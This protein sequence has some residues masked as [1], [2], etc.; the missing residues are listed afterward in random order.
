MR[1]LV[2]FLL[3]FQLVAGVLAQELGEGREFQAGQHLMA[4]VAKIEAKHFEKSIRRG[5]KDWQEG[6]LPDVDTEKLNLSTE[7]EKAFRELLKKAHAKIRFEEIGPGAWASRVQGHV[8]SFSLKELYQGSLKIDGKVFTFKDVPLKDLHQ[9]LNEFEL[10]T[11]TTWYKTIFDQ[12]IGV[13]S[14]QAIIPFIILGAVAAVIILY[15][16][17]ELKWK[18]EST[19]EKLGELTKQ[20]DKQANTCEESKT[21]EVSYMDTYQ[22]ANKM[23]ERTTLN[24]ATSSEDALMLTIKEQIASGG[25][26][27]EDC[28]K[29][30]HEAGEKLD[31]DIPM[32]SASEISKMND[33]GGGLKFNTKTDVKGALFN[34]C[35]SYNALGSCMEQF[36]GAHVDTSD[37]S[38]FKDTARQNYRGWKKAT[39]A[40]RQ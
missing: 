12:T 15:T 39:G 20:L 4:G 40:G 9:K 23:S 30:M 5:L 34:L 7:D 11:K 29:L 19:V 17:Y 27:N 35:K 33:H 24:S 38:S 10:P 8:V 26:N 28:Y 25:R 2:S 21:S 1:F 22:M 36:I 13:P 16:L 32:P 6:K 3:S 14:A 18:P 37:I 31:I